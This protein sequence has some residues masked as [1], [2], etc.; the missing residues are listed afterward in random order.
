[1]VGMSHCES[2]G[3]HQKSC[4]RQQELAILV[5]LDLSHGKEWAAQNRACKVSLLVHTNFGLQIKGLI[6]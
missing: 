6:K 1:M 5:C 4:C 3:Q 2:G